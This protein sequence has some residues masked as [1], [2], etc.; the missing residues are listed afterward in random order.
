MFQASHSSCPRAGSP[1]RGA[2]AAVASCRGGC[3]R[4]SGRPSVV[5]VARAVLGLVRREVFA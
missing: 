2:R 1:S 4:V 5:A 3:A